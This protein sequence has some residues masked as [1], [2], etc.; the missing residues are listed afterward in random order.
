MLQEPEARVGKHCDATLDRRKFVWDW[1]SKHYPEFWDV[2]NH[3]GLRDAKVIAEIGAAVADRFG[4][5]NVP[6]HKARHKARAEV[7]LWLSNPDRFAPFVDRVAVSRA[8]GF[9]WD[10]IANLSLQE[11]AVVVSRLARMGNPFDYGGKT[12][13]DEIMD[14]V[15]APGAPR[16][17]RP[18]QRRMAYLRGSERL[19]NR[20]T[21]AVQVARGRMSEEVAA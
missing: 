1:V 4:G 10:V 21:E 8:L 11:W 16:L 3:P 20:L 18:S 2:P 9:D 6:R 7:R 5:E 15:S 14:T 17:V 19:R 12:L 13:L